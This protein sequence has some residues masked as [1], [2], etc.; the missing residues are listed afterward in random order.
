MQGCHRETDI[1]LPLKLVFLIS[2]AVFKYFIPAV[3]KF[4]L[5]APLPFHFPDSAGGEN[6]NVC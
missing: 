5:S 6:G 3:T 4:N 2:Y 1:I